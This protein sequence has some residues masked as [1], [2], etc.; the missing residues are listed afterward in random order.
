MC[1]LVSLQC[2]VLRES[3]GAVA[4]LVWALACVFVDVC[5]QVA[6]LRERL[7]AG[8][9][10]VRLVVRVDQKMTLKMTVSDE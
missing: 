5:L 6:V 4:A 10:L 9:A 3:F 7:G 1:S 2:A 8:L